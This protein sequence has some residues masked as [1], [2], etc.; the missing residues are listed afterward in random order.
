MADSQ[1]SLSASDLKSI[2]DAIKEGDNILA[3]QIKEGD[4]KNSGDI[5]DVQIALEQLRRD[6]ATGMVPRDV[7]DLHLHQL[8]TEMAAGVKETQQNGM[9]ISEFTGEFRDFRA[10]QEEQHEKEVQEQKVLKKDA[11][12]KAT[13]KVEHKWSRSGIIFG[14][15]VGGFGIMGTVVGITIQIVNAL[16]H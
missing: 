14:I 13:Q 3:L 4:N 10:K 11:E 2:Y 7:L 9:K 16:H 5:K 12:A 1:M 8:R 15:I 6:V